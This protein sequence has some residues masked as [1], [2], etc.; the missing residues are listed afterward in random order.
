MHVFLEQ[1]RPN[2]TYVTLGSVEI[3]FSYVTPVAF[4]DE[5]GWHV[6]QNVWSQTT[7]RHLNMIPGGSDKAAR[8]PHDEFKAQLG[9]FLAR[10]AVP[11]GA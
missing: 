5:N 10:L 3:A 2:L 11:A 8:I 7:G 9:D 4:R 6:S 1:P